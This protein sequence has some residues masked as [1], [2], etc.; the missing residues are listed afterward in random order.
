M[1][2]RLSCT[3]PRTRSSPWAPAATSPARS[4][5]PEYVELPGGD[6]FPWAGE[7]DPL[8]NEVERFLSRVRNEDG[9]AFDRVLATV[10]FTDIVDSTAQ[11]AAMGDRRWRDLREHHDRITRASSPASAGV[12]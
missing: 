7:Q 11:A 5:T 10:L 6:H 3:G 9:D 8:V 2:R 1:C 4:P 12:R